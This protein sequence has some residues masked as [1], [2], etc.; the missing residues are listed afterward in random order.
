MGLSRL[1]DLHLFG[2]TH[3]FCQ[4]FGAGE[5]LWQMSARPLYLY[6]YLPQAFY[7]RYVTAIV[8]GVTFIGL[9][10]TFIW[11]VHELWVAPVLTQQADI[12]KSSAE[13]IHSD[14]SK[15]SFRPESG[16]ASALS[17]GLSFL[18]LQSHQNTPE[19]DA[20]STEGKENNPGEFLTKRD[21]NEDPKLKLQD[22]VKNLMMLSTAATA[23][24]SATNKSRGNDSNLHLP[25][26]S[27]LIDTN[28]PSIP[29]TQLNISSQPART[30][31]FSH[32]GTIRDLAYSE[33][34]KWL[35][36]TWLVILTPFDGENH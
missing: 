14:V 21:F 34:G 6:L 23:F 32:Y 3:L 1:L 31:E 7:T 19:K 30:I 4:F 25:T 12:I 18:G 13:S 9:V 26:R 2:G 24:R 15:L 35:A 36:V 10:A 8:T 5:V 16:I 20:E 17:K 28:V 29:V 11:M 22:K 27:R 33:N